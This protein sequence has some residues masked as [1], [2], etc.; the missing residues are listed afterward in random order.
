MSKTEPV[1]THDFGMLAVRAYRVSDRSSVSDGCEGK[2][3]EGLRRLCMS[4]R[5]TVVFVFALALLFAVTAAQLNAQSITQGN[6]RGTITDPSGAVVPNATV[7][8]KSTRTGATQTRTTSSSG[9]YEFPLVTP[10]PYTIT[11]TAPRPSPRP[12]TRPF[13]RV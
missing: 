13:R 3:H 12:A 1:K 10:G 4:F 11:I 8:L 6:V 7:T 9:F 2:A 5:R